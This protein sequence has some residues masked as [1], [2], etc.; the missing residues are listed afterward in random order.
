MG[1][2]QYF[3]RKK[4]ERKCFIEKN[5]TEFR[6][7]ENCPCS[8]DDYEWYYNKLKYVILNITLAIIILYI[9]TIG[10]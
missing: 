2:K 7:K 1:H 9:I 6:H 4:V 3:W 8:D 10:V 5:H